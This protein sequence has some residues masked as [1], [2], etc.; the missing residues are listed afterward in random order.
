MKESLSQRF[1]RGL[2]KH[3][4][5]KFFDK[6]NKKQNKKD[7]QILSAGKVLDHDDINYMIDASL[8]RHLTLDRF[9]K[10]FEKKLRVFFNVEYALTVNS[11]SSANLLALSALTSYKLGDKKIKKGDEII[12]I[13][14]AFSTTISPIVQNDLVPV[15]VDIESETYNIDS[16]LIEKAITKKTKAI[17]IA[18]TMGNPF[19]VTKVVDICNKYHLWLI[20][21][22]CDSFGSK[23]KELLT[24]TFGH[25]STL[26]FYPAH[27]ITTGEGGDF[28]Q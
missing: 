17:F 27:H 16:K 8:D 3:F 23:Y 21:D 26:S 4:A 28:D 6:C 11:G 10:E 18:H 9:N 15:F 19:D 12:T 25:I 24:G 5:R 22:N 7:K 2:T 14:S 13:A 1:Y 20:E